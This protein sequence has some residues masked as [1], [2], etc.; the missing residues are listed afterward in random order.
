MS[1]ID[2][3]WEPDFP[4]VMHFVDVKNVYSKPSILLSQ[5]YTADYNAAKWHGNFP[6]AMRLVAKIV[7]TPENIA[8][9]HEIKHK[10]PN[11]IL[12]AVSA[13]EKDAKHSEAHNQLPNALAEYISKKTGF[14]MDMDIVQINEAHRTGTKEWERLAFRPEFEGSVQKKRPHILLDDVCAHGGTFSELR[15][16]IE[17]NGGQ[18]VHT[19]A[20]ALGGH[21]DRIAISP[22]LQ[23]HIVDKFGNNNLQLFCKGV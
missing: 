6:A 7:N 3:G 4:R 1:F 16:Y 5:L 23:K 15:H 2:E 12:V 13:K 22:L 19:G 11:A 18:V 10:Y 20:L 17:K 14:E 9:L 21:G 8:Q